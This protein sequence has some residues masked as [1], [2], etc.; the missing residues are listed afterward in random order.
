MR[1]L[2]QAVMSAIFV[3]ATAWAQATTTSNIS[4]TVQDATSLAVPGAQ[5]KVTQTETGLARET[6][7]GNDGGYLITNLPLNGR[8]PQELLLLAAPAVSTG[9]AS[10]NGRVYPGANISV[11]GS[12]TL[13]VLY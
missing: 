1:N 7:T 6:T 5:V 3:C 11:A 8:N 13:S 9:A 12:S 10:A 4:G 2:L